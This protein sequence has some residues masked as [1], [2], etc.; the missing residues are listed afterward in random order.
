MEGIS[1]WPRVERATPSESLRDEASRIAAARGRRLGTFAAR[2]MN[3]KVA[4]SSCVDI[5]LPD[6]RRVC[7]ACTRPLRGKS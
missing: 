6:R 4:V 2:V 1:L 7:Y 3:F 5:N